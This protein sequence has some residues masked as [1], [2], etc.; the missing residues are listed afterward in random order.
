MAHVT[1]IQSGISALADDCL[2]HG[3]AVA[4][5][6]GVDAETVAP[7]RTGALR[8]SANVEEIA[9]GI[10]R[11]SFGRGLLD[12]RAVYQE[13]GT[14]KMRAQPYLRPAAYQRRAM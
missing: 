5:A 4:L 9:R 12:G 8:M 6:I 1:L 10:W 2:S 14:S 13:L 11:I 3:E 7:I